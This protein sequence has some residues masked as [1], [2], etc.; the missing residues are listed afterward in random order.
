MSQT[1]DPH[2]PVGFVIRCPMRKGPLQQSGTT[3]TYDRFIALILA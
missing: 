2:D 3:A 1:S